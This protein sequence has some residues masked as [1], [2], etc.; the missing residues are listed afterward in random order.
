MGKFFT[1]K[2]DN[3]KSK[4]QNPLIVPLVAA[5]GAVEVAAE[6]AAEVAPEGAPEV[7]LEPNAD[8][9]QVVVSGELQPDSPIIPIQEPQHIDQ[10]MATRLFKKIDTNQDDSINLS[11]L[12]KISRDVVT[13]EGKM[14]HE[15]LG[16]P[17]AVR[18]ED[19]TKDAIVRLFASMHKRGADDGD[20]ISLKE[21]L[22]YMRNKQFLTGLV[23]LRNNNLSPQVSPVPEV[24]VAE[25]PGEPVVVP[26][27]TEPVVVPV[28]GEPVVIPV[29]EE[30]VVVPV[31]EEPVA[32]P[33]PEEPASLP[34]IVVQPALV[35]N[36]IPVFNNLINVLKNF[37]INPPI[38]REL[39]DPLAA[40]VDINAAEDASTKISEIAAGGG[41]SE[42]TIAAIANA[43]SAA[44]EVAVAVATIASPTATPQ[45]KAAAVA[46]AAKA[47]AKSRESANAASAFASA[48]KYEPI[49]QHLSPVVEVQPENPEGLPTQN[50]SLPNVEEQENQLRIALEAAQEAARAAEAA[51]ALAVEVELRMHEE[52]REAEEENER[53]DDELR[54]YE[55]AREARKANSAERLKEMHA[56]NGDNAALSGLVH[57]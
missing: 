45:Q 43:T 41:A 24:P 6:V 55:E 20:G 17:S 35:E 49:S 22:Q 19:G 21:W 56:N 38:P 1:E 15:L 53:T 42:K 57:G 34:S 48:I 52:A 47:A 8:Q 27:P 18:Q 30:P 44:S 14:L 28:P 37:I 12:V 51:N 31:P 11:E 4:E 40:Q 10:E 29:P 39:F 33:V 50:E 2:I 23:E 5:E 26:V 13:D 9:Q 36:D 32:V 54:V 16:L 3:K 46:D 7:P 25:V